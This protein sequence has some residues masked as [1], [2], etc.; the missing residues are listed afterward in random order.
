MKNKKE[1]KF[2]ISLTTLMIITFII[3]L[4]VID[5]CGFLVSRYVLGS[6]EL[7]ALTSS[8]PQETFNNF[9]FEK[10]IGEIWARV[11]Y[12]AIGSFLLGTILIFVTGKR[13]IKPIKQLSAAT[14][15]VA[16]GDFDIDLKTKRKDEIGELVNNFNKMTADLKKQEYLQKEFINNVSHE[17]KTPLSSIQ[18]VTQLL[19]SDDLSEEEKKE[20]LEIIKEE[21]TRLSNLSTNILRLSKI[22]NQDAQQNKVTYNLTEQIRKSIL[23]LEPSWSKKNIEFDIELEDI[24]INAEKELLQ[25][26]WI[27]LL[28]NAIKFSNENGKIKVTSSVSNDEAIIEIHDNGIGI[29]KEKIERIFDRFYQA[30]NSHSKEGNGLGLTIVKRIISLCNGEIDVESKYEEGT[31]FII[32]LPIIN[33]EIN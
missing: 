25:Q 13:I 28:N 11:V 22:E 2:R 26:V 12:I 27:N 9:N 6:E 20:Y 31:K 5:L 17:F 15:K 29:E 33:S 3:A 30:D 1:K 14:K 16:K 7:N 21:T 18:G 19:E 32:K 10:I 4:L 8:I 23:L 24:N